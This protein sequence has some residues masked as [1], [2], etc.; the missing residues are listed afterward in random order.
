MGKSK[1]ATIPLGFETL[2]CKKVNPRTPQSTLNKHYFKILAL[3]V[4]KVVFDANTNKLGNLI[5]T[6]KLNL[7]ASIMYQH[8]PRRV[9]QYTE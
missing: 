6:K 8:R 3:F 2:F 7:R 9:C 5:G 1:P 4:F